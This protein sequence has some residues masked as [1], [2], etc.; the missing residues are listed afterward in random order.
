MAINEEQRQVEVARDLEEL[1]RT[2]A[3]STKDVPTPP[4]SYPLLGE[5]RATADDLAQV[6]RQL[7]AWHNNVIDGT[8]YE[9]E[10]ERGDGVTGTITAAAE[11]EKAA[12]ALSAAA[13]ALSAAHS[14]NG[15][16]RWFDAAR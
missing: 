16:V 1:A 8:H 10:D 13:A 15:V 6:C 12:T 11:L 7:A 4:D 9:G 3:H 2:L 5:L 14:A